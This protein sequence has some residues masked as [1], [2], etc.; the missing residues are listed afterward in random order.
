VAAIET[1]VR[2]TNGHL[3]SLSPQELIDCTDQVTGPSEI[4]G[5]ESGSMASAFF[6]VSEDDLRSEEHYPYKQ[7]KQTSCLGNKTAGY[8]IDDYAYVD[9]RNGSDTVRKALLTY[10]LAAT[11][12]IGN[13]FKSYQ[14]GIF[15]GPCGTIKHAVAIIGYGV[16]NGLK[17]WLIKNSWGV[18]W[19]EA[20]FARIS[21]E[22]DCGLLYV[23][24]Y[25]HV[26]D[27]KQQK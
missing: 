5:C 14:S 20:G 26:E 19:G 22:N 4:N 10:T 12:N 3:V 15:S 27:H 18:E 25:P 17:Y 6:Y 21:S 23:L 7:E 24:M 16:E 13:E 2:K 9:G 1:L 11:I 8:S